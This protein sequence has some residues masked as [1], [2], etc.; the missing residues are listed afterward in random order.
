[1]PEDAADA[2]GQPPAEIGRQQGVVEEQHAAEAADGGAQPVTA[3]DGEVRPA[4]VAGGDQLVDGRVDRRVLTADAGPGEEAEQEQ[5]PRLG[6]ERGRHGRHQVEPQCEQEQ[7]LASEAVGELAE[8]ER[9]EACAGDV[10]GRGRAAVAPP[11]VDAAAD[12]DPPVEPRPWQAVQPSGDAGPD[13]ARFSGGRHFLAPS[14]AD[15]R[16]RRASG[17]RGERASPLP[18]ETGRGPASPGPGDVCSPDSGQRSSRRFSSSGRRADMGATGHSTFDKTVDKTNHV[19][20]EIEQAY[21]W[22]K[23]RRNHSYDALRA[24]LHALRDR[25]TVDECADLAA[26]LPLLVRGVYY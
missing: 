26:Q 6:R 19:L 4:A 7:F 5:V 22:P 9:T 1:Q 16:C 25:L 21:G 12:H 2:E 18:G 3:V 13:R 14:K 23:E 17:G 11:H 24:V 15:R 8:E 20:K 10:E